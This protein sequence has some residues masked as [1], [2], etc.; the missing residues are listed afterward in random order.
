M[1]DF[2]G[3]QNMYK[4]IYGSPSAWESLLDI[5]QQDELGCTE[6]FLLGVMKGKWLRVKH[7][8]CMQTILYLHANDSPGM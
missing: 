6:E 7:S 5:G 4:M 1:V 2:E 8:V 3:M